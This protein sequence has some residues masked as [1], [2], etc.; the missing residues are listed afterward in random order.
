MTAK[1]THGNIDGG[2]LLA[3]ISIFLTFC[4]AAAAAI[5]MLAFGSVSAFADTLSADTLS[6]STETDSVIPSSVDDSDEMFAEYV[7]HLF[8]TGDDQTLLSAGDRYS[9]LSDADQLLYDTIYEIACDIDS[10]ERSSSVITLNMAAY[11]YVYQDFSLSNVIYALLDDCPFELYWYDKTSVTQSM[12]NGNTLVVTMPVARAYSAS[13]TTG[14]CTVNTQ[15]TS[16]PLAAYDRAQEVASEAYDED[17]YDALDYYR[18]WICDNTGYDTTAPGQNYGDPWQIIYVF[19]GDSST[20]VVCEGYAKAFKYLSDLWK[21]QHPDSE[22]ENYLVE[23]SLGSEA[24]MWN[25]VHM[26]DGKNYLADITNCDSL[27][28]GRLL[29]L[30]GSQ[31]PTTQ[32]YRGVLREVSY[33]ITVNGLSQTYTYLRNGSV[34]LQM[35]TDD[36]ISIAEKNYDPDDMTDKFRDV[37][38]D[39]AYYYDAVYVMANLGVTDGAGDF[40]FQP[41]SNVTRAQFVTFLYRLA[42]SPDVSADGATSDN[43]FNAGSSTANDSETSDNAV[44]GTVNKFTDVSTASYAWD[45]IQ[46]AASQGIAQGT[47]DDQFSP[48]ASVTRAQAAAFIWRWCGSPEASQKENFTDVSD[49]AYYAAAVSW[50]AEYG[51]IDGY[52]GSKFGPGDTCTRGQAVTFLNRTYQLMQS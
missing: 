33:R 36:E 23:G 6:N 12:Q 45:A 48:N 20:N 14:T 51:I 32:Y 11:G 3:G 19:D 50:G 22:L 35:Y 9:T 34:S 37:R 18:Q 17:L 46:W 2:K 47:S 43:S 28:G 49:G 24:H 13:G 8:Q 30:I 15:L 52:G 16:A 5:L 40:V 42:G 31:S 1:T 21:K 25:I 39:T 29:F 41:G 38:D 4:T 7:D 10:G 26:D 44:D 27:G